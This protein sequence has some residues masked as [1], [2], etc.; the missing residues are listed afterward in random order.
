MEEKEDIAIALI[1]V[2]MLVVVVATF[3]SGLIEIS[4]PSL[5]QRPPLQEFLW[6]YRGLDVF[7][8]AFIVFAAATAIATLFR[9]EKGPGA[10][11][12]TYLE[13]AEEKV[14]EAT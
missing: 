9:V 1:A 8:Q 11:E 4:L 5:P 7:V 14:Q 13:P 3:G 12:T 6:T 10:Q 2:V